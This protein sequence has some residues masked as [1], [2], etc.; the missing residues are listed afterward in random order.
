MRNIFD[1]KDNLHNM[2]NIPAILKWG[3]LNGP[4]PDVSILMPV[5]NHPHYFKLALE[6]AINQDYKGDY[7]IVV[8]DN[9]LEDDVDF[10]NEFE[11]YI[12]KKNCLKVL[13]YKNVHNIDGINSFN[14]LPQLAR[15]N[16][17]TFLHDDDELQKN[18]LSKL[19]SVKRE[20]NLT[21][22]LVVPSMYMIDEKSN[23]F[24]IPGK[25]NNG[26]FWKKCYKM[27]MYDWLLKSHTNGCGALHNKDAFLELGGYC[28]EYIPTAD[29]AFY[30]LYV[31]KYGGVFVNTPLLRY[32]IAENDSINVYE[33]CVEMTCQIRNNIMPK[34][35]MPEIFLKRIVNARKGVELERDDKLFNGIVRRKAKLVDKLIFAIA[36]FCNFLRH[37]FLI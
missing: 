11:H 35:K 24:F 3:N 34:I 28:S 30:V 27:D 9:N 20:K 31:Y 29:Y 25:I 21:K 5:Y 36:F 10:V 4:N 18:C 22:E 26:I 8:L 32:R 16:Y 14:R 19:L 37:T 2:D 12:I 33:A 17:F 6:T 23:I 15:S 13:Y 1:Y 7:E